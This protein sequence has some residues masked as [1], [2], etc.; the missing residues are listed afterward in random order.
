M[1]D[2]WSDTPHDVVLCNFGGPTKADEVEPFLMRLFE[3]PFIIRVPLGP[4][5]RTWLAR[6]ISKKR[7]PKAAE[8][9]EKIGFSPINRMTEIQARLLETELRRLRPNTRVHVVNRYTAPYAQ[10]VVPRLDPKKSR[11]FVTSLYPHVCH[12]TTVSSYRDYDLAFAAHHGVRD[13]GS[14]RVFSWWQSKRFLNLGEKALRTS[15]QKALAQPGPVA[16]LFSAHGL[17]VRYNNRGDPYCNE[18]TGHFNE[19]RRRTEAWLSS[20]PKD[21][22]PRVS[23]DLSFQSRVGPVEW[24]KPYTEETIASL[25]ASSGKGGT[26]VM[27][28]ISFTADHIET[29]YEMD[30]T[31]KA[32]AL[33]AGFSHYERVAP[34]NDDPELA[35]SMRDVLVQFGF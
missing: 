34:A 19:L 13:V 24:M 29:L 27:V 7:A 35:L 5:F 4:K 10:D 17:P 1:S 12:S 9:Y 16:V 3:D 28:P 32:Q 30:V 6:R 11:I 14:V 25:G 20:E 8:E 33:R 22:N 26:I 18:I 2:H 15:L 23:W 21:Q 31:Y